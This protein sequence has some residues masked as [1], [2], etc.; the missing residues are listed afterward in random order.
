MSGPTASLMRP[1]DTA[2]IDG[3][4]DRPFADPQ[5]PVSPVLEGVLRLS[6][7][8]R[9]NG[10][11]TYVAQ[12]VRRRRPDVRGNAI[13]WQNRDTDIGPTTGAE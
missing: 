6:G 7:S 8:G 3:G 13:P 11:D 4:S 1:V 12:N 2:A 10:R 5:S 9:R